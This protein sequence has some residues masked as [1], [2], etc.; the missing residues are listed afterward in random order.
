MSLTHE[1]E[2]W[3]EYKMEYRNPHREIEP[4]EKEIEVVD[5]ALQALKDAEMLPSTEYDLDK[6]MAFRKFVRENFD[7]PWTGITPRMQ[8]L[9]YAI[10]AITK[11]PV[12]VAV[13]IFVG[14]TFISNAG[15]AVGPGKVYD[16][17]RLVGIEI[18]GEPIEKA[19]KNIATIDKNNECEII[20]A[21]AVEW[22]AHLDTPI[23][24]F[25]SDANGSYRQILDA[26]L[27]GKAMRKGT[28]CMAH[29]SVNMPGSVGPYLDLVRDPDKFRQSMNMIIDGEG[30]E[31]SLF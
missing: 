5:G 17:K 6:F 31:V 27:A 15:T 20:H 12:M 1:V 21:D 3:R 16:A 19:R 26:A 18:E 14:N 23:D 28:L 4:L 24:L 29:N 25:Y 7:I 22:V 10:N 9:I 2:G 30:L 11:P 8:R 13:G